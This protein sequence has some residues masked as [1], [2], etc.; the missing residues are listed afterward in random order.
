MLVCVPK[1]QE[2]FFFSCKA[3]PSQAKPNQTK[4][5]QTKPPKQRK[6]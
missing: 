3:K 4:P 5:N 6:A 1:I 2:L